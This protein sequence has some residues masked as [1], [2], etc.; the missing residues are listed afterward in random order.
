MND[1]AVEK[2]PPGRAA[3]VDFERT[4]LHECYQ[5]RWDTEEAHC[6]RD[7]AL[8]SVDGPHIRIAE[9]HCRLDE[10]IEHRFQVERR[11]ADDLEHV[12]GG[13]LLLQRLGKLVRALL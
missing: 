2:N 10:R 9:S 6:P 13:G 5:F 1:A 7:V 11:A 4:I 12:G 8:R 3:A